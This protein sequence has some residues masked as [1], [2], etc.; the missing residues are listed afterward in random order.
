MKLPDLALDPQGERRCARLRAASAIIVLAALAA[1]AMLVPRLIHAYGVATNRAE[2]AASAS[3]GDGDAAA[4]S[5]KYS[6]EN[7]GKNSAPPPIAAIDLGISD[8]PSP[9]AASASTAST[10]PPAAPP[11]AQPAAL[12]AASSA[13]HSRPTV[14]PKT[15]PG[16]AIS[17]TVVVK[18]S[19]SASGRFQGSRDRGQT[20]RRPNAN[21]RQPVPAHPD[22]PAPPPIPDPLAGVTIE[23]RM[24][25]NPDR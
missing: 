6:A 17:R 20:T 18:E 5:V 7:S 14:P 16:L 9:P 23:V 10:A 24:F 21:P 4:N 15:H 13:D 25:S 2:A 12:S 8:R 3:R 1:I 11:S 19:G 22:D